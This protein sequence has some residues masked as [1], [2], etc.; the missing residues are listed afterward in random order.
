MLVSL[1]GMSSFRG[2]V[3]KNLRGSVIWSREL[4][5]TLWRVH[6]LHFSSRQYRYIFIII[7]Q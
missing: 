2:T 1:T 3:I 6:A 7:T 5:R 4:D